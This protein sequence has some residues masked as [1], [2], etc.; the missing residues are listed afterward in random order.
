MVKEKRKSG[1]ADEKEVE[2]RGEKEEKKKRGRDEGVGREG[3]LWVGG[4]TLG[5]LKGSRAAN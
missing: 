2:R 5:G 1:N 3:A 4:S